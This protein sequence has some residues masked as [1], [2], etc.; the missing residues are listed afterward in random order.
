MQRIKNNIKAKNEE[1]RQ[2][3]E[4]STYLPDVHVEKISS[5]HP[6][7]A[8]PPKLTT[9]ISVRSLRSLRT[10]NS[11]NILPDEVHN[12]SSGNGTFA[13][14]APS[15]SCADE[16]SRTAPRATSHPFTLSR[17]D[18]DLAPP[19]PRAS[20]TTI[21]GLSER[22]FS[23]EHLQV[24]LNDSSLFPK[25]T[26]FLNQY[27]PRTLSV[28]TH[29]LETQKAIKAIEYAN[30]IANNIHPLSADASSTIPCSAALLDARFE[31][32]SGRAFE[33]LMNDALPAFVTHSLVHTVSDSVAKEITGTS[34]PM[35]RDLVGNLAEVF[36]L[37]DPSI[38]DNPIVFASEGT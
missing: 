13:P 11:H 3:H 27:K 18:F 9:K 19:A 23:D 10:F 15:E 5:G 14:Q 31:A 4:Q 36:C 30:A 22:L 7:D 17:Q 29:Y 6:V 33:S 32:R 2:Q 24:I 16:H 21:D 20:L 25:L 34:I 38:H 37:T 26:A 28:L 8:I 12:G 35:I 1:R